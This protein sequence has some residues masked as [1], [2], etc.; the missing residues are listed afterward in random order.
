MREQ[1]TVIIGGQTFTLNP[2]K[3]RIV[4]KW[5][6]KFAKILLPLIGM[7][8]ELLPAFTSGDDQSSIA[9]RG[10]EVLAT[11]LNMP[12]DMELIT[13]ALTESLDALS[14]FEFEALMEGMFK[15]VMWQGPKGNVSLV[16]GDLIDAA[17]EDAGTQAMYMLM[18]EVARYDK[19]IPF[20]LMGGGAETAT[21]VGSTAQDP[22]GNKT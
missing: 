18:Y 9:E 12:I 20:G 22:Q 13:G 5:E 10:K 15:N 17:F 14:D 1:K 21:T 8:K 11:L 6:F 3:P 7:L 2:T 19:Y 4:R 16:S